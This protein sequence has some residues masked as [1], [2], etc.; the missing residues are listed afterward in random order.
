MKLYRI[1]TAEDILIG[2][3]DTEERIRYEQELE[4]FYI[5]EAIKKARIPR[6]GKGHNI[7]LSN[8]S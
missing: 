8:L 7:T 1:E 5:G 4:Q 3:A 6:I 2:K